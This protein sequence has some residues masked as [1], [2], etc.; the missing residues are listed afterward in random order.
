MQYDF[1]SFKGGLAGL[2]GAVIMIFSRESSGLRALL[3][4]KVISVPFV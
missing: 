3:V 1:L 4:L 2:A